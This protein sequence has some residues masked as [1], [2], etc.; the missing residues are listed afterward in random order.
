MI[1]KVEG[2][3]QELEETLYWLELLVDSDIV[4]VN[5]LSDLMKEAEGLIAILVTSA[6]TLKSRRTK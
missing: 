2:A 3:L 1:S 5:L 6:K 4:K